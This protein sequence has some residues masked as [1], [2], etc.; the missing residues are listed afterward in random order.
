MHG[1]LHIDYSPTRDAVQALKRLQQSGITVKLVTNGTQK[2]KSGLYSRL[3][4]LGFDINYNEIFTSLVAARKLVEAKSLRPFC[5]LQDDAM[6]DFA[7]L[8]MTNPNAVVV[9]LAPDYFTYEHLNQA[10]RLLIN[11]EDCMLIA[12]YKGRYR[13]SAKGLSLGP[14]P[15]V[16][17]L[18]YASGKKAVVVGKPQLE[19]FQSVLQDFSCSAKETLMIGDDVTIDILG[20]LNADI[21]GILVKTG[22]YRD[23]DEDRL[24]NQERCMCVND[25]AIAV[26][27]IIAAT[28]CPA[29]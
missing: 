18:E 17:A 12:V 14:G 22:K 5:L 29:L 10:F 9:G 7:G 11:N 19:F 1:T 15:F 4:K 2:S 26:D 13:E 16:E 6:E 27:S 8:D 3:T 24:Q 25:F 28:S 23:G 20:A 21:G